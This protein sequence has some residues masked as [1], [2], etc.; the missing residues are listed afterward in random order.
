MMLFQKSFFSGERYFK[1]TPI[2]F[3]CTWRAAYTHQL[4]TPPK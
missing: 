2:Y 4:L 1:E 3:L